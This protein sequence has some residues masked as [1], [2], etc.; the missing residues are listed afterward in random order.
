MRLRNWVYDAVLAHELGRRTGRRDSRKAA[1]AENAAGSSTI[2]GRFEVE[3]LAS[4]RLPQDGFSGSGLVGDSGL[5]FEVSIDPMA[6]PT[7]KADAMTAN[8]N[9]DRCG[10]GI[11]AGSTPVSAELGSGLP[12]RIF[13]R[14]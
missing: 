13:W 14:S 11:P 1:S 3:D 6:M 10:P 5:R 4:F 7:G 12:M 9:F 8:F 2:P